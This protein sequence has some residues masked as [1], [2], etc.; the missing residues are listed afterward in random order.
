MSTKTHKSRARSPA[1]VF[2]ALLLLLPL[3]LR[4][5]Q[6]VNTPYE[7][8]K[9]VYDFYFNDPDKINAALFWIRSLIN[10][11]GDAPYDLAP[12]ELDIK[13]IIHGREIVALT[14]KN[15]VKYREAVERMRYYADFGVEFR[16]C[17]IA[18]SDFGY[19]T[20]DFYDF[21]QVVPSAMTELVHWQ[22]KGY[23]LIT[24]KILFKEK[25]NED[26]R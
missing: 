24:P 16:V 3:S 9:V 10:P 12:E 22:S 8:Q 15:Y 26:I 13:V 5:G 11:L 23:G 7:P 19:S 6:W 20:K 14:K 21:V 17:G 1:F 18:M 2:L 4:G 25:S